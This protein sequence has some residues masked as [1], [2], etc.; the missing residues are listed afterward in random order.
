MTIWNTSVFL[1]AVCQ[2]LRPVDLLAY[3]NRK[4]ANILTLK[5]VDKY[6]QADR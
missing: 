6:K 1:K 3:K 4:K 5:L 2:A